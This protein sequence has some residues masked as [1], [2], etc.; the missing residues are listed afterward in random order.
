M[1]GQGWKRPE[2]KNDIGVCV[3]AWKRKEIITERS[4]LG[5]VEWVGCL[6]SEKKTQAKRQC[7]REGEKWAKVKKRPGKEQRK[8]KRIKK[9]QRKEREK[10]SVRDNQETT[11]NKPGTFKLL[12]PSFLLLCRCFG[13]RC[14]LFWLQRF[15]KSKIVWICWADQQKTVLNWNKRLCNVQ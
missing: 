14:G 2:K 7:I 15:E 4:A 10:V 13:D 11:S 8:A 3:F 12:L 1:L 9:R 6:N 5:K